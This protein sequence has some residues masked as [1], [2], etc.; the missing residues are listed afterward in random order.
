[1]VRQE[2]CN[3]YP[4]TYWL[5]A[6]HLRAR[7]SA[8][9]SPLAPGKHS[10]DAIPTPLPIASLGP[11]GPG[12]LKFVELKTLTVCT[13]VQAYVHRGEAQMG[14]PCPLHT[15]PD[16][17]LVPNLSEQRTGH[18]HVHPQREGGQLTP[19]TPNFNL[20]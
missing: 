4:L 14:E 13:C 17:K 10:W 3:M 18:M 12:C 15:R 19:P 2:G 8:T 11:S 20:V 5:N 1:M 9:D 16:S 7:H 6:V